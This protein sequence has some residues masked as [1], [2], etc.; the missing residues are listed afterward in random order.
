MASGVGDVAAKKSAGILTSD[1]Q[2]D[3]CSQRR[4]NANENSSQQ[5]IN[6]LQINNLL[7]ATVENKLP[8]T[9]SVGRQSLDG[10]CGRRRRDAKRLTDWLLDCLKSRN[11]FCA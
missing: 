3:S 6:N 7:P 5:T 1:C 9:S 4:A 2:Q 11:I 10:E 8:E